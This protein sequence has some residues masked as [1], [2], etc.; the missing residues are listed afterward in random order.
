[1]PDG[2]L[3]VEAKVAFWNYCSVSL[4]GVVIAFVRKVELCD[5]QTLSYSIN[6]TAEKHVQIVD[7]SIQNSLEVL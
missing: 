6:P 7:I 2:M 4:P 3:E 5:I 1:M